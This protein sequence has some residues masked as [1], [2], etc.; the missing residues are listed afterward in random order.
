MTT[1]EQL[2]GLLELLA[3][4]PDSQIC[5]TVTP[6]IKELI[7]K[8]VDE[9]EKGIKAALDKC[10]RGS[11]ATDFSMFS[12]GCAWDMSKQLTNPRGEW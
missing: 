12:M 7:G 11:L 2:N 4:A 6:S 5:K 1:Y 10:A 3:N 8:P 9:I